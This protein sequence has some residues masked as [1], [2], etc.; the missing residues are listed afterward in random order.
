MCSSVLQ[1]GKLDHHE[2]RYRVLQVIWGKL[3]NAKKLHSFEGESRIMCG[4]KQALRS[5]LKSSGQDIS[6]RGEHTRSTILFNLHSNLE[7]SVNCSYFV[8]VGMEAGM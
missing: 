3:S 6:Y 5:T 2:D 4:L 7:Y 8:V 1:E